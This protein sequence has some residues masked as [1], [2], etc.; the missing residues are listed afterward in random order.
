M[1]N[2]IFKIAFMQ[3]FK[4]G[5]FSELFSKQKLFPTLQS[6]LNRI[7]SGM[8]G[9]PSSLQE[10]DCGKEDRLLKLTKHPVSTPDA[11][12]E[13]EYDPYDENC[14]GDDLK[15]NINSEYEVEDVLKLV[16]F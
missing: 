16:D 5:F 9:H 10:K 6:N 15:D 7:R 2:S 12:G 14:D 11:P 1:H 8:E 13:E 3:L 4:M